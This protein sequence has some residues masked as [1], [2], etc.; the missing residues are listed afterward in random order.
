MG[1]A[2]D[3]H[4][5][6][7]GGE[8]VVEAG[9]EEAAEEDAHIKQRAEEADSAPQRRDYKIVLDKDMSTV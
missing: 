4:I 6:A 3:A 5:E 8:D 1:G 9:G 2:G 7:A